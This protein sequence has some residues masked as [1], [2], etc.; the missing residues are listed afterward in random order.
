MTPS[1]YTNKRWQFLNEK[2]NSNGH[3]GWFKVVY[4]IDNNVDSEHNIYTQTYGKTFR[5][6]DCAYKG[7]G[8]LPFPRDHSLV[9]QHRTRQFCCEDQIDSIQAGW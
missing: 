8:A 6:L 9:K 2:Q 5:N 7:S 4:K 3:K 1:S